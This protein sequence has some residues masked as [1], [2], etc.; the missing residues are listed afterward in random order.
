MVNG[1]KGEERDEDNCGVSSLSDEDTDSIFDKNRLSREKHGQ[2]V[3][4]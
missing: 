4:M 2:I 1:Y 3:K